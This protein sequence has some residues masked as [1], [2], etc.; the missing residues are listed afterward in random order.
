MLA[1]YNTIKPLVSSGEIGNKKPHVR[2][3]GAIGS[4]SGSGCRSARQDLF[5]SRVIFARKWRDIFAHYDIP[6][7]QCYLGAIPFD[8][9]NMQ[10]EF[11]PVFLFLMKERVSFF[12]E[13]YRDLRCCGS[14]SRLRLTRLSPSGFR[15]RGV[16]SVH[17]WKRLP[18]P[19]CFISQFLGI[20]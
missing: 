4:L 12:R 3:R 19:A 18:L 2:C 16:E 1:L 8:H 7:S 6:D 10:E 5:H 15:F 13:D 9:G 17:E 11:S 20:P 14:T